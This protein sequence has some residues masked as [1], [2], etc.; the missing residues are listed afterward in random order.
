[1]VRFLSV[2]FAAA[3]LGGCTG[4]VRTTLGVTESDHSEAIANY[5]G[6][7]GDGEDSS[8]VA[9]DCK[10]HN[11]RTFTLVRASAEEVPVLVTVRLP[12]EWVSDGFLLNSLSLQDREFH[13]AITQWRTPKGKLRTVAL[14]A[15]G[16]EDLYIDVD[17]TR[18]HVARGD[19]VIV[20]EAGGTRVAARP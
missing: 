2:L 11:V 9:M 12:E 3:L 5:P 8:K 18:T 16:P 14:R 19:V 20:A 1:M 15:F 17:G 13:W 4:P 10:R 7:D 6:F